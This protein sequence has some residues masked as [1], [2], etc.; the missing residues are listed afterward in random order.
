MD[1]VRY[2]FQKNSRELVRAGI[3]QYQ[4]KDYAYI[5]IFYNAGTDEYPDWR[6]SKKGVVVSVDLLDELVKAVNSLKG[7]D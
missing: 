6:P 4:G 3:S 1:D 7:D 2:E 5:R